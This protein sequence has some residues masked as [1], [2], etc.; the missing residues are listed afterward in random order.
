MIAAGIVIHWTSSDEYIEIDLDALKHLDG[1]KTTLEWWRKN[2]EYV[3]YN[4]QSE[5]KRLGK[6]SIE[7]TCYY[8]QQK[9]THMPSDDYCWG[10][11]II[12]LDVG[13]TRG[14]AEWVDSDDSENNGTVFWERIDCGLFKEKKREVTS[15]LQR[16]QA[17]FKSAL[18]TYGGCCDLSGESTSDVLEAA[19][20]IPSKEGGAE[21]VQNGLLLRADIHRLYDA[22]KFMIDP[23]NGKVVDI[24]EDVSSGY[25]AILSNVRIPKKTL[26]RIQP[27]LHHQWNSNRGINSCKT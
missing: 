25:L 5:I 9:N 3:R 1:V 10:K 2:K 16:K 27:A 20:I 6:N 21:V 4:T 8:K 7:L 18:L 19:H 13:A 23:S 15:R 24:N 11:S 22:G 17:M 12:A 14:K 26:L